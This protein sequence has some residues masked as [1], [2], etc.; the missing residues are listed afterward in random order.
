MLKTL[1]LST[2]GSKS[3]KVKLLYSSANTSNIKPILNSLICFSLY[4][5]GYYYKARSLERTFTSRGKLVRSANRVK[6]FLKGLNLVKDKAYSFKYIKI[7]N[8][9]AIDSYL[10]PRFVF[11]G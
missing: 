6:T 1:A 3:S 9:N 5:K 2:L 8:R 10:K 7:Y 11:L 4:S